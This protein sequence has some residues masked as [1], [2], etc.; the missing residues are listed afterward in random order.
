MPN[1]TDIPP[2]PDLTSSR[3]NHACEKEVKELQQAISAWNEI[4]TTY[5]PMMQKG[6]EV[7][8]LSDKIGTVQNQI[9]RAMDS[10]FAAMETTQSDGKDLESV[11]AVYGQGLTMFN[12]MIFSYLSHRSQVL[13]RK[14][15]FAAILDEVRLLNNKAVQ[16]QSSRNPS[17]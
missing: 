5:L 3:K 10:L 16:S 15:I 17:S 11:I 14:N 12:A 2:L 7:P 4:E 6:I 9:A 13:G 8:N 1:P